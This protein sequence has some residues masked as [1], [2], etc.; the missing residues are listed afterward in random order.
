MYVYWT[1]IKALLK[2]HSL[3]DSSGLPYIHVHTQTIL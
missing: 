3:P 1:I 2:Y